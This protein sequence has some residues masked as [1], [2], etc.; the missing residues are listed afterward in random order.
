VG[1]LSTLPGF[2]KVA[3]AVS[4][5][6]FTA[7]SGLGLYVHAPQ[8]GYTEV[9]PGWMKSMT[10]GDE[11]SGDAVE[12]RRLITRGRIGTIEDARKVNDQKFRRLRWAM[13]AELAG[14]L[15][16]ALSVIARVLGWV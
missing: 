8:G 16:L 6:L 14:L 10:E 9:T 2:A 15:A 5:A 7:G 12:A 13:K 4:L 11:W 1:A 3:I